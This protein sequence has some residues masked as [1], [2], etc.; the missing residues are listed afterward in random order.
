M[1]LDLRPYDPI[2]DR[3]AAH[4]VLRA[5]FARDGTGYTIHP[6]DWDWWC[7]H[8]DP[9]L[10]P[11]ELFIGDHLLVEVD[12]G[13]GELSVFGA[14]P[15]E[16]GALL[17]DVGTTVTNIRWV[18]AR[19]ATRRDVLASRGFAPRGQ[20][21]PVFTRLAAGGVDG[22]RPL[23]EGFTIR[24]LAGDDEAPLRAAAAR[25]AFEST[26]EPAAHVARYRAFMASP[27][28]ERDHDIVAIAP[29]GRVASFAVHWP[30]TE[31]SLAQ[32][33]PVGTDPDFTRRGLGRAVIADSLARIDA[34]GVRIARVITEG[35]RHPAKALYTACGFTIVDHL[36]WWR[37]PA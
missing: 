15:A 10:A 11:V 36:E 18:P 26:M 35:D 12:A 21:W 17:D 22:V 4:A 27:A 30:D 25:R 24:P 7:F 33:E 6:G 3:A 9:Q 13:T 23:P 8:R 5:A 16:L 14:T 19:D 1:T 20:P 37:R 2:A 32:F 29:D 34:A 31:L 28:Y